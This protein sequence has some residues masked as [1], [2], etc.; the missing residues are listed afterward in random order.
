[1]RENRY[2]TPLASVGGHEEGL[3]ALPPF[4]LGAGDRGR[5]R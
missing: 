2:T 3:T 5:F 4:I 1:M